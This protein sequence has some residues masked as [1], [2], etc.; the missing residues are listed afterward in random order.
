MASVLKRITVISIL[1][2][3]ATASFQAQT[4]PGKPGGYPAAGQSAIVTVV[5]PGAAPRAALRYA[6]GGDYKS[7]M[8]LTMSMGMSMELPGLPSQPMQMPAMKMGADVGVRSVAPTGDVTFDFAY[9]SVTTDQAAG[10]DPAFAS[11]IQSMGADLKNVRGSATMN[12]RGATHGSSLDLGK[13]ADGRMGQ[14][15]G[16]LGNSLDS[17]TVP[18][19]EEAVGAG[20]RWE[21]RQTIQSNGFEVYQKTLWELVAVEGKTVRLKTTIEQTAPPQAVTNPALPAG[22]DVSLAKFTGTGGGTVT[23]H[24]DSLIPTSEVN[25]STNMTMNV[26]AGGST[27]QMS[28]GITLK[29]SIAPGKTAASG[30]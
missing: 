23:L 30:R 14:M 11:L 9:T 25:S 10:T 6:I 13:L 7:H 22:T 18:L 28:I 29:M 3:A 17:L 15:M 20:A 5:S 24:L 12:T 21:S 26:N 8:D 19:P 27:Q 2:A 4:A 16:S 1:F